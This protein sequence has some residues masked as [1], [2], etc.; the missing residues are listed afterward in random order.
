MHT[1]MP[2]VHAPSFAVASG[3]RPSC[4]RV[5]VM[6]SK[7]VAESGGA[8]APFQRRMRA[9]VRRRNEKRDCSELDS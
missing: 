9:K 2:V 5:A 7:P 3:T 4:D 8:R 1:H 6:G